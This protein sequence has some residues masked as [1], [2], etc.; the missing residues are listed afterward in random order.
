MNIKTLLHKGTDFIQLNFLISYIVAGGIPAA[1]FCI[2]RLLLL[3]SA[4]QRI[5]IFLPFTTLPFLI[6]AGI[7]YYFFI[8]HSCILTMANP[9]IIYTLSSA[10]SFC[11]YAV[12][13]E[14]GIS[15]LLL[16][17]FF[18]VVFFYFE[19]MITEEK[20]IPFAITCAA[21]LYIHPEAGLQIALLLFVL[22]ILALLFYRKFKLGNLV[23]VI[24]LFLFSFG[25]ASV[26]MVFYLVPFYTEHHDYSYNGFSL[27]YNP[28][29]FVSRLLPWTT[30]SRT[31]IGTDNRMD[32]YFGLFP[33]IL[34]L[35]FFISFKI[36]LR[37]KIYASLFT[38]LIVSMLEFSPVLYVFNL[39]HIT[40]HST[41]QASFFLVFWMLYIATYT[42]SH[43]HSIRICEILL[44]GFSLLILMAVSWLWGYKNFHFAFLFVQAALA[45]LYIM[46]LYHR[47]TK[48]HFVVYILLLVC[49]EL[50]SNCLFSSNTLFYKQGSSVV[51]SFAFKKATKKHINKKPKS[52]IKSRNTTDNQTS[53]N[54]NNNK[55]VAETDSSRSPSIPY[56]VYDYIGV[57]ISLLCVFFLLFLYTY[58]KRSRILDLFDRQKNKLNQIHCKN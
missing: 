38:I 39:F 9:F 29:V 46:L 21:M 52:T 47:Q 40:Y 45:L 15:S 26:R 30:A 36:S 24:L 11:S 55:I 16:Y 31:L 42:L 28:A 13:Q 4:G 37:K 19:H 18:P 35:F 6:L 49:L 43:I 1:L 12:L 50:G 48:S 20:F 27:S 44:T 7:S 5:I 17:A 58:D 34:F 41:L 22:A 3:A 8:T 54:Q 57:G 10:Y 23:H 25:L 51:A 33:L 32:L 53:D 14:T 2:V 56:I